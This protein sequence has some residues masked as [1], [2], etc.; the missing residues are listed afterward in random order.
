M[1][2]N[3]VVHDTKSRAWCVYVTFQRMSTNLHCLYF[4]KITITTQL[5]M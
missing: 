1:K 3:E 4:N 5:K 2:L